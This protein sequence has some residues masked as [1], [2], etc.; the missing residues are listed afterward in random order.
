MAEAPTIHLYGPTDR[1][2]VFEFLRSVLPEET[3]ARFI[4]QWS[5]KI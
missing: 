1:T 5:W 4:A 2:E 3:S